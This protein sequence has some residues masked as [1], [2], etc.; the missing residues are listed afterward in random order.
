MEQQRY[1]EIE[2]AYIETRQVLG[3]VKKLK[4][5]DS[6]FSRNELIKKTILGHSQ[7]E[8]LLNDGVALGLLEV[9]PQE[10]KPPLFRI[11]T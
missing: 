2:K 5:F 11:A 1:Q 4:D 7:A 8:G 9:K 6:W 10:D 3:K